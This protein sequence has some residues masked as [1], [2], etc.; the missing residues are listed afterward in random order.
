MKPE[1]LKIPVT[2]A[3]M[4]EKRI[5]EPESVLNRTQGIWPSNDDVTAQNFYR[6]PV[7][8]FNC[9]ILSSH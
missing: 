4:N 3:V 1:H 9:T 7:R 8:I 5:A 6:C 2:R